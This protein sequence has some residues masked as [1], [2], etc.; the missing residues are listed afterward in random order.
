MG[1]G[2]SLI[3]IAAGAILTFAVH[4]ST[5]TFNLH[6][7]GAILLLVGAI[8]LAASMMFWSSWGFGGRRAT[9]TTVVDRS[10]P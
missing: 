3:S 9:T 7:V 8:G 5:S 4:A 2:V 10:R 6:T 1:I